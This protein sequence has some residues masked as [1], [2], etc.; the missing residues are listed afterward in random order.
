[1]PEWFETLLPAHWLRPWAL[2]GLLVAA[3]L[4]LWGR[5][6]LTPPALQRVIAP[7]LLPHLLV[8]GGK[9][10]WLHPSDTLALALVCFSIALAGPAWEREAP[11]LTQDAAP[12]ML[13][14]DL[15][16]AA[17][18]V[19]LSPSRLAVARA[20]LHRLLAQRGDAPT[21]LVVYAGSAHLVLPPTADREVL[22]TYLDA[23]AT[24]LMPHSGQ[25]PAQALEL[26]LAWLERQNQAGTVLF[27]TG[28]WPASDLEPSAR[29]L[30]DS[31]HRLLV[32]GLGSPDGGPLRDAQGRYVT[33]TQGRIVQARLEV[34][35]LNEL[36]ERTGAQLLALSP[37]DSDIARVQGAVAQ[38][39]AAAAERDTN[40]RWHDRGPFW[41]WPGL[42]ALLMSFRRGWVLPWQQLASWVG[43]L[44]LVLV[45][46]T[47]TGPVWAETAASSRW[48]RWQQQFIDWWLTPDQQGRWWLERQQAERAAHH[49]RDPLWQGA[50]WAQAGQW[51]AAADA[52]ARADSAAAWF[53]Q[54]Q[55]LARLGR[56]AES[57]SAYDQA[58]QRA[59]G[60]PPAMA[61]RERVLGLQRAAEAAAE[62]DIDADLV[63]SGDSDREGSRRSHQRRPA[64][65]RP[66]TDREL[67]ELW[68]QRMDTSPSG[69][70]HRKFLLQWQQAQR[71]QSPP[72]P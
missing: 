53:N 16:A 13:V 63:A 57:V 39:H 29:A 42:L 43:T 31:P 18:A 10:H 50:A 54:A 40:R 12:L 36:R 8:Q 56:Y 21:G 2:W 49:F 11:W 67:A 5:R 72:T 52:F 37:D 60:W 32:W 7:H 69:F 14:V 38:H 25:A 26:A 46:L 44:L 34:K 45:L 9:R 3:L 48:T 71:P 59:P 19:D 28:H 17:N 65:L 23:L 68:L 4:A 70:L 27:L 22:G 33:D 58:L 66:L 41:I 35:A 24:D 30:Q 64:P 51:Q 61:D 1:M 15:S 20:K 47:Q 55:M 6:P 62:E